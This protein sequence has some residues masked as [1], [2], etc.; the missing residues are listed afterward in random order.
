MA[1]VSHPNV[2][3]V[4]DAS[5]F[6]GRPLIAMEFVQGK[7]L[8]AWQREPRPWPEVVRMYADAGR[9][10][11]AA[12]DAQLVHRDFK[13]DNVLVSGHRAKVTDF[14]V[15]RAAGETT[16]SGDAQ[17]LARALQ[18]SSRPPRPGPKPPETQVPDAPLPSGSLPLETP[19]T[20]MGEL[21]GTP[22]Y[23]APEQYLCEEIDARTNQFAFCVSLYEALYGEKP[24]PGRGVSEL[25]Q[26]VIEGRIREAPKSSSV[27]AHVRRVLLRGLATERDQRYPSMH[28]LLADLLHDTAQSRRRALAV[29]AAVAALGGAAVWG[30]LTVRAHRL[31]LCSGSQA[32]ASKVWNGDVQGRIERAMLATGLPYAADTFARTHAAI[33]QYMQRWTALDTETCTATRVLGR[34][35]ETL[36]AV[37]MACLER[38]RD[39]V[40]AL[41][42]VLASADRDVVAKAVPAAL[43]LT[44]ADVCKDATSLTSIAPEPTN[45]TRRAE[46]D[47]I[48][49]ALTTARAKLEA[50]KYA[51]ARD[52]VAPLLPRARELGYSP[53]LAEVLTVSAEASSETGVARKTYLEQGREAVL[54][55]DLGRDEHARA[56]AAIW[57]LHRTHEGGEYEAAERWSNVARAAIEHLGNPDLLRAA[58]LGGQ[59]LLSEN[60][61]ELRRGAPVGPREL[62]SRATRL[63]PPRGGQ[64]RRRALRS[65]GCARAL[66]RGQTARRGSRRAH[67]AHAGS[68]ASGAP[69]LAHR[70][71][72]CLGSSGGH[73]RGRTLLARRH[74]AR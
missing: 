36:M 9:G 32:E 45:P 7:T 20:E 57:L 28:A 38:R 42:T 25:A 37:R 35:P 14:G 21:M 58:W 63:E 26:R 4:F 10:L 56:R 34:Q 74:R 19:L 39:E 29:V 12:H 16:T 17:A 53:L 68:R 30:T 1:R 67:R 49:S 44:P 13:P 60:R 43:A 69:A 62:G 33:D 59:G 15:A 22:G 48:R 41:A 54:H 24:F 23:M 66:R 50:G 47:S 11:A 40:G 6:Q 71:E 55:A 65:S 64:K 70:H 72:L 3:A 61:G 18:S 5:S 2:V 52:E 31:Q 8:R 73:A 46:L 51:V 27:P